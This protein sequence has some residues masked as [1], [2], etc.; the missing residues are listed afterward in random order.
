MIGIP[1]CSLMT[2]RARHNDLARPERIM[3]FTIG[4]GKK[5]DGKDMECMFYDDPHAYFWIPIPG[6]KWRKNF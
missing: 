5:G 6:K 4:L 3:Q 1:A 2:P